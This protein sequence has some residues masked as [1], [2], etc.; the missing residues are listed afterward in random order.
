MFL[1]SK[2]FWFLVN[3][4][5]LLLVALVGGTLLM[6]TRFRRTGRALVAFATGCFLLVATLPVG[7]AMMTVLENRFP[8]KPA[9]PHDVAGII[10]LG[11]TVNQW[12]TEARGLPSISGGGAR[13]TEFIHLAR[14][15]PQA[16]LIF[17][18]G[19]GSIWDQSRKETEVARTFFARLDLDPGRVVFED[20]SRNT[21]ENALFSKELV[22]PRDADKWVLITSAIH[23]PRAIGVF[24]RAGWNVIAY[25]VDFR[26]D[27]NHALFLSFDPLGGLARVYAGLR[28]WIGLAAYRILD[29]T[30][31]LLPGR[32][33]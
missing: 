28:E 21:H 1:V 22:T 23:M 3:P 25:P 2:I 27:G 11:G 32:N 18:G 26:T 5:N 30:D 17:T 33:G 10:V 8:P 16:K 13:L 7:T 24:R 12:L 29:R 20:R 19:S 14:R 6:F 31:S 4:A 9:I 15:F